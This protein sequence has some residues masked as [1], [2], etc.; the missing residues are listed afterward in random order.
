MASVFHG[1]TYYAV[2]NALH[3]EWIWNYTYEN[4]IVGWIYQFESFHYKNFEVYL[5][6]MYIFRH[7]NVGLQYWI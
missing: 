5:A 6:Y 3:K 7:L 1:R 2:I 4:M